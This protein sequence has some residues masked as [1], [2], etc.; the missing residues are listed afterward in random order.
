L[1]LWLKKV[2]V[3]TT[4]W[5]GALLLRA[6]L[7]IFMPHTTPLIELRHISK[8]FGSVVAL[9]DV[10]FTL[11]SNEIVGL[12][13]DNG[14][15]KSSLVKI[16]SGVEQADS[17]SFSVNDTSVALKSYSVKMAR[18]L[19][20]ETVYQERALCENQPL[21]RNVFVGRHKRNRFGL[22]DVA[23][24]K[25]ATE[26]I[27]KEFM[28]LRGAGVSADACVAVLSGGERQGLAIGRAMY[29]AASAV[30][31]DE[32]TTALSLTEVSKVLQFIQQIRKAGRSAVFI[33]HN[34]RHVY[35]ACD[36]FVILDRG[37]VV[38]ELNKG[39]ITLEGLSSLL[40]GLA[41]GATPANEHME[42]GE[43]E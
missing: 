31:L 30:I 25:Q 13:G 6:L 41:C 35:E 1:S 34:M 7:N 28:G 23:Y 16:L 11:G 18:K 12:L 8:R 40:T 5:H 39:D 24:E 3:N 2:F 29:F 26:T 27:L 36:R 21:W 43:G 42:S 10:S 37:R 20:I 14:A 15:G 22:I 33:S 9:E 17:G 38:Q 19:G 4:K 32:P